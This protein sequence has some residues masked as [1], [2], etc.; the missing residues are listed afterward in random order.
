MLPR[1]TRRSGNG[2]RGWAAVALVLFVVLPA[3]GAIPSA[4][5][6]DPY[7]GLVA[8]LNALVARRSALVDTLTTADSLAGS[9]ALGDLL[10]TIRAPLA[11]Q[12]R[13]ASTL[14]ALTKIAPHPPKTTADPPFY[15]AAGPGVLLG[16]HMSASAA[17]DIA[18]V[19]VSDPSNA[20][21]GP[22]EALP[23]LPPRYESLGTARVTIPA[24]RIDVLAT[25]VPLTAVASQAA[26]PSSSVPAAIAPPWYAPTILHGADAVAAYAKIANVSLPRIAST[27]AP[28]LQSNIGGSAA[29]RPTSPAMLTAR[30]GHYQTDG[31]GAVPYTPRVLTK[32]SANWTL[33]AN[34]PISADTTL[35]VQ[36]QGKL[37]SGT[38][39][40]VTYSA[41]STKAP[42]TALPPSP[43]QLRLDL[44]TDGSA[45]IT[46]TE[47]LSDATTIQLSV[48]MANLFADRAIAAAVKSEQ[49]PLTQ[50]APL[51]D[52]GNAA[53]AQLL[54]LYQARAKVYQQA[55]TAAMGKN[56]VLEQA[57]WDRTQRWNAYQTALAAWKQREALWKQ[58][59][60]PPAK[61]HGTRKTKRGTSA[62]AGAAVT[63][64]A[65]ATPLVPGRPF[66]GPGPYNGSDATTDPHALG[67][68]GGPADPLLA[69]AAVTPIFVDTPVPPS[70]IDT[71]TDS[72]VPAPTLPLPSATMTDT[73]TVPI[74]RTATSSPTATDTLSP[75]I[76]DSPTATSTRIAPPT[77]TQTLTPTSTQSASPTARPTSTATARRPHSLLTDGGAPSET[78]TASSTDSATATATA[79]AS[80]TDTA[81]TTP[82]ASDTA[83]PTSDP[84]A[85]VRA[86]RTAEISTVT[87]TTTASATPTVR[88]TATGVPTAAPRTKTKTATAAPTEVLDAPPTPDPT[89]TPVSHGKSPLLPPGP[90][91]AAVPPPGPQPQYVALPIPLSPLP[92]WVEAPIAVTPAEVQ[93]YEGYGVNAR[94]YASMTAAQ[95][96]AGGALDNVSG[97]LPPIQG[98]I[99]TLWGG[100]TPFQSFH[101]G[102][103][104][105]GP[106][107]TPVHAAAD[108][109]V[110]HAGL[111]VPGDPTQSYGNSVV[112]VH[113]AHIST[114]YGHM[115]LGLHGLQVQ[116]GQVVRQGQVIGYEGQT[117]WA[118][119][120]HVHFEMRLDNVQFDPLLLVNLKLI[121]G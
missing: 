97:Y 1:H 13:Q 10:A 106:D 67:V 119:G 54:P 56:A 55:F 28:R 30:L 71:V 66:P 51:L 38:L 19:P 39:A 117:G 101:P 87:D 98:V 40:G 29:T 16:A 15:R 68:G 94:G 49:K 105:A 95:L 86:T 96:I 5:A 2:F 88:A 93:T 53:Y 121:T 52:A 59:L 81:S 43:L 27:R 14:A 18:A 108:G 45:I 116:V 4:R 90:A 41:F 11:A 20:S 58:S 84:I 78:A 21:N 82:T 100:S 9:L 79:P 111:A 36:S 70:P 110:V 73:P 8:Q 80:P 6:S 31:T 34:R 22:S 42:I 102:I 60:P 83:T 77:S 3:P 23:L 109:I 99:T 104:I 57:W 44:H 62:L 118:T 103:D 46:A 75:T 37:V 72:S 47:T 69:T 107:G 33:I 17:S 112:I 7:D 91:P 61:G 115:Q 114:L 89:V 74:T 35:Q 113:N 24:H 76:T 12:A 65:T 50:L 92:A 64:T 48:R 26:P 120:P 25:D 85:K 32:A 63:I